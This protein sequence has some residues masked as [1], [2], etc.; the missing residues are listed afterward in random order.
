MLPRSIEIRTSLAHLL[1]Q[2]GLRLRIDFTASEA[3]REARRPKAQT[4]A[5]FHGVKD[6]QRQLETSLR[7]H[8]ES[9]FTRH[10]SRNDCEAVSPFNGL[11]L[12]ASLQ[13]SARQARPGFSFAEEGHLRSWL[14]LAQTPR[15]RPGSDTEV[16]SRLLDSEVR[17]EQVAR[18]ENRGST[19]ASRLAGSSRLGMRVG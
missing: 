3:R 8:G 13:G 6:G 15:M 7:D 19:T 17:G 4:E 1:S 14:F 12:P 18:H 9:A 10:T 2:H 5:L 11:S 16:T